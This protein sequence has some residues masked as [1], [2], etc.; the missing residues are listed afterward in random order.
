MDYK[1]ALLGVASLLALTAGMQDPAS[2]RDIR[3]RFA[4]DTQAAPAQKSIGG[5]QS[6]VLLDL[7]MRTNGALST[8]AIE[9]ALVD[10][11]SNPSREQIESTPELLRD[12]AGLGLSA[13]GIQRLRDVLGEI[14]ASA[15]HLDDTLRTS[16]VTQLNSEMKSFVF[17]QARRKAC[18][19][20]QLRNPRLRAECDPGEVGQTRGRNPN[21]IGQVGQLGGGYR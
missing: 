4:D 15:E 6:E 17:A 5:V 16:V 11:F 20:A 21:E 8:D 7:L 13:E 2:A 3:F 14:V 18:T 10:M 19:P 12:F 9:N 1:K